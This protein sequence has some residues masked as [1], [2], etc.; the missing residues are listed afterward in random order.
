M[1]HVQLWLLSPRGVCC[2]LLLHGKAT[3]DAIKHDCTFYC[4]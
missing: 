2:A 1:V 3:A 4:F